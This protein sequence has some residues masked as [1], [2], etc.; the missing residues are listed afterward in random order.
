MAETYTVFVVVLMLIL[1]LYTDKFI[2]CQRFQVSVQVI[3]FQ[4]FDITNVACSGPFNLKFKGRAQ[5]SPSSVEECEN[6]FKSM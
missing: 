3:S 2:L 1:S 4:I 5:T 6:R